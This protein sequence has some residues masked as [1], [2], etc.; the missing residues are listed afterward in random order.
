MTVGMRLDVDFNGPFFTGATQRAI[1]RAL[2]DTLQDVTERGESITK[3]QLV[4][5]HGLVTGTLRRSIAGQVVNSRQTLVKTDVVY[6]AWIEGTSDRNK[7]T[8]FK[9]YRMFRKAAQALDR[10]WPRLLRKHLRRR[11]R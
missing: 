3:R 1:A 5:G 2:D 8:R 10:S 6:G 7:T 11:M 4:P 9:G